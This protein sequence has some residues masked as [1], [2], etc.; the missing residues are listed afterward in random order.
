MGRRI[1]KVSEEIA[2]HED[3]AVFEEIQKNTDNDSGVPRIDVNG[4][5]GGIQAI[6]MLRAAIDAEQRRPGILPGRR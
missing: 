2:F 1:R 4:D 3:W 5:N 6:R